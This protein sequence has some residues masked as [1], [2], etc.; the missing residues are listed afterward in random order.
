MLIYGDGS[1]HVSHLAAPLTVVYLTHV[2]GIC[3]QLY[4]GSGPSSVYLT[5]HVWSNKR[6][7]IDFIL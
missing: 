1:S 2:Y 4:L 5:V 3:T 6:G 7:H